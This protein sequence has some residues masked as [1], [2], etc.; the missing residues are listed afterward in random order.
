VTDDHNIPGSMYLAQYPETFIY[1]KDGSMAARHAGASDW[2]DK[3]V[4]TFID[5]L[6]SR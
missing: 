4:I 3:S 1:A 2:S 6:Q 5:S